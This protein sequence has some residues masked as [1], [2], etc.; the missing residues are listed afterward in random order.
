MR[1][2]RRT[3]K[4]AKIA[5]FIKELSLE[6]LPRSGQRGRTSHEQRGL[7]HSRSQSNGSYTD[8]FPF[9]EQLNLLASSLQIPLSSPGAS[10]VF[11]GVKN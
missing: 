9:M 6:M 5:T 1:R 2:L 8:L 4:T 11:I 10:P 7:Y 3:H